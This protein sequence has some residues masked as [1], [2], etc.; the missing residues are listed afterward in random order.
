MQLFHYAYGKKV[1]TET[2]R[3][4]L[5]GGIAFWSPSTWVIISLW[6]LRSETLQIVHVKSPSRTQNE[7]RTFILMPTEAAFITHTRWWLVGS[8]SPVHPPGLPSG[9]IHT[10]GKAML[11]DG[12]NVDQC[13]STACCR[14]TRTGWGSSPLSL[15]SSFSQPIT[16][17]IM[18]S[19]TQTSEKDKT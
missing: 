6:E 17:Q 15:P 8:G 5:Y 19:S 18:V 11:R 16:T 2:A 1:S 3:G 12:G 9:C 10:R 14:S 13:S 4:V 7:V